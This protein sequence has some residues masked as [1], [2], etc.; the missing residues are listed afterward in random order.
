M[1]SVLQL[2][3]GTTT[4]DLTTAGNAAG[5]SHQADGFE[6][7]EIDDNGH[8]VLT[9]GRAQLMG[10]SQADM[11]TKLAALETLLADAQD[12]RGLD[13]QRRVSLKF[14]PNGASTQII[15]D[16]FGGRI[17]QRPSAANFLLLNRKYYG[18]F[19][20]VL[21]A[22]PY[23]RST[24]QTLFTST[25]L[26]AYPGIT[27]QYVHHTGATAFGV[28]CAGVTE[29]SLWQSTKLSLT[30][31]AVT[32]QNG[33]IL[34]FG[35]TQQTFDRLIMGIKTA[36]T[37]TLNG[38][39]EYYN[40]SAWTGLTTASSFRSGAEAT[41][42]DTAAR[43]GAIT[44]TVPG[45]WATVAINGVT[46][47]WVRYRITSFS[48]G[49]APTR[50]NGPVRSHAGLAYIDN[51]GTVVNGT[52]AARCLVSLINPD[53]AAKAGAIAAIITGRRSTF[54]PPVRVPFTNGD[55]FVPSTDTTATVET[56]AQATFGERVKIRVNAAYSDGGLHL[57]GSND[58]IT[59][60][61]TA[62]NKLDVSGDFVAEIAFNCDT[63]PAGPV[64]LM[65]K[66]NRTASSSTTGFWWLG[67]DGG[68]LRGLATRS[69]ATSNVKK[70]NGT[71]ELETGVW[72]R[73]RLEFKSSQQK[74]YL[75]LDGQLEGTVKLGGSTLNNGGTTA[76][77][78][79]QSVNFYSGDSLDGASA[80]TAFD[81]IVDEVTIRTDPYAASSYTLPTAAYSDSSSVR[82][83]LHCD[84]NAASTAVVDSATT[85]AAALNGTLTNA[86]N[87]SA[88]AVAGY[89]NSGSGGLVKA[90]GIKLPQCLLEEYAGNYHVYLRATLAAAVSSG[91]RNP[92][93]RVQLGP[94]DSAL[95]MQTREARRF[96]GSDPNTVT[97]YVVIDLGVMSLPPG[98][99][100]EGHVG[101]GSARNWRDCYLF[102]DHGFS[103]A[104]DIY[105]DCLDFYPAEGCLELE[106]FR[107]G[108]ADVQYSASEAVAQNEG[109]LLDGRA[110]DLVAGKTTT[111]GYTEQGRAAYARPLCAA[112]RLRPG[113]P[114]WVVGMGLRGANPSD[115]DGYVYRAIGD[116]LTLRLH[117]VP[118]W[119][120]LPGS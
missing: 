118:Q 98:R 106:T 73:A 31:T 86:G 50:M 33:D 56:D 10:S 30:P 34:Y 116:L 68:K 74:L 62:G 81:G 94:G 43:L 15:W 7:G 79:G 114:A 6:I 60:A 27:H 58:Y 12:F 105:L 39:W 110:G 108:N 75:Y 17:V 117:A 3:D 92:G 53:A 45:D 29:G 52:E 72:Y 82:W 89:F 51:S 14:T 99:L 80:E 42:F 28:N 107:L 44:W 70:A 66:W 55:A 36:K 32:P 115:G 69:S 65:G 112:P 49:T 57:D 83:L 76:L 96:I 71:T 67:I 87:T 41:E 46:A 2:T 84:D 40:G 26:R 21:E 16:L 119:E 104:T 103:T 85:Y 11:L 48:S 78:V 54:L 37:G 90:I 1:A 100:Y 24:E 88:V 113:K 8:R 97:G 19:G 93:F 64:C 23:G 35:H 61:M 9:L 4:L 22:E 91:V 59:R 111:A 63:I 20:M 109:F 47:Y 5:Y 77:Q 120:S 18:P 13:G 102:I 101:S 95:P 38:V 25:T